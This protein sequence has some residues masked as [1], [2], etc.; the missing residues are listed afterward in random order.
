MARRIIVIDRS[1]ETDPVLSLTVAFW[2]DVPATLAGR[3]ADPKAVS[4][5]AD[6]TAAEL[7]DLRAGRV[8]ERVVPF[9]WADDLSD[10]EVRAR[11]LD[12]P[13]QL[14]RELLGTVT[15]R[16]AFWRAGMAYDPTTDTWTG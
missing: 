7:A 14:R 16:G 2:F 13:R 1:A 4:Q 9:R 8:V 3:F 15:P 11:I 6:V 10:A 12:Y 5:V